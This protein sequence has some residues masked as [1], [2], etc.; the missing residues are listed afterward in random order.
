LTTKKPDPHH[1]EKLAA[2]NK[3]ISTPDVPRPLQIY[4]HYKG[5]LYAIVAVGIREDTLVPVIFYKSN[6]YGTV[7]ERTLENFQEDVLVDGVPSKRF[8]RVSR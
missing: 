8:W 6:V 7:M 2:W 3:L 5:G 4:E 1:D